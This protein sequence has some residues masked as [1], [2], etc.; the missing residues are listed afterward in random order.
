MPRITLKNSRYHILGFIDTRADG[1][2]VGMNSRY[3]IVGYYH[4]GRDITQ[5][6][7]YRT[8]GMGNLLASLMTAHAG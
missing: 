3:Q 6:A 4:P 5:D 2:Q 8:F 1:T 7:Q